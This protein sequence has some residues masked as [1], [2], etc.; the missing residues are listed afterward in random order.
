M[1]RYPGQIRLFKPARNPKLLKMV[2]EKIS[3]GQCNTFQLHHF[4]NPR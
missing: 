3:V 2:S 4:E 1:K